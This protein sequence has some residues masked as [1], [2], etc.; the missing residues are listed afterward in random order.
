[1]VLPFRVVPSITAHQE[2]CV[3][4]EHGTCIRTVLGVT[5]Q[6]FLLCFV[7]R[8]TGGSTERLYGGGIKT[9]ARAH[10]LLS[11]PRNARLLRET[12][13]TERPALQGTLEGAFFVSSLRWIRHSLTTCARERSGLATGL[14]TTI[15]LLSSPGEFLPRPRAYIE[16]ASALALEKKHSAFRSHDKKKKPKSNVQ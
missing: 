1:M 10:Q 13:I 8:T 15:G 7:R 2:S 12:C 5:S 6:P 16:G 9:E 4:V 14:P 11:R 3:E